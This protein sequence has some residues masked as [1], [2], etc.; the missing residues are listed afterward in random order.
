MGKNTDKETRKFYLSG[1]SCMDCAAKIEGVVSK[2]S[3]VKDARVNFSTSLLK[4]TINAGDRDEANME[5]EIEDEVSKVGFGLDKRGHEAV[6]FKTTGDIAEPAAGRI[7]KALLAIGGVKRVDFFQPNGVKI[8]YDPAQAQPADLKKALEAN[9]AGVSEA[10]CSF[11]KKTVKKSKALLTLTIITGLFIVVGLGFALFHHL[12]IYKTLTVST[13]LFIIASAIGVYY[14]GRSGLASVRNLRLDI[15]FLMCVAVIGA[16]VIGEYLEGATVVFLFMLA[17][18]LETYTMDKARNAIHALVKMSPETALVKDGKNEK[19]V[20]VDNVEVG[21]VIVIKPGEMIPLDGKVLKGCSAV[22]LAAITGESI[23]VEKS[24]GDDVYAGAVNEEGALEVEVTRL[25]KESTLAGIIH[26]IEDAQAQ[27]APFQSFVDKFAKYYTPSVIVC[28]ILV[29]IVPPIVIGAQFTEWFYRALVLLVISCPCA[30]VISTPVS[31][32]SGITAG[33]RKGILFKGGVYLERIGGLRSMAI[34]KTGTLTK[35]EPRVADVAPLNG[36]AVDDVLRIAASVESRSEHSIADAI[37]AKAKEKGLELIE[38][39]KFQSVPGKGAIMELDNVKYCV[40]SVRFMTELGY[41]EPA[42]DAVLKGF[43]D[44]GM[45][46]I[47]VADDK[48][49][50][51]IIAVA[52]EIRKTS[53]QTIKELYN[54]GVKKIVML[55]GDHECAAKAVSREL[56]MLDFR[57]DLPPLDKV[58]AVKALIRDYG[59]CGMIGDGINDAPALAAATV[60]VAM[61]SNATDIAVES[62][63]VT[64]MGDDLR[65]L[66][67]AVDLGKRTIRIIKQ[68][69]MTALLLKGVFLAL[70]APGYTTLWMAV[71]ADMGASLIV[72]CN[73]LRLLRAGGKSLSGK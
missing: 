73:G 69:I 39:D 30:L 52:D 11:S 10:E 41:C 4:V 51:G 12:I 61:G 38:G 59:S 25:S 67:F 5:A 54:K 36:P 50:I 49:V 19:L 22:N 32:I 70:T 45:T 1:L 21:A 40:G 71:G 9:G 68:N 33:A 6:S 55:T 43:Y 48:A 17:Q 13:L 34:D 29:A 47:L 27:K 56:D 35:G 57:S 18:L 53:R 24:E 8:E 64:I 63:D 62:S 65:K 16:A 14:I 60:G 23:P 3:W 46:A 20:P 15:N 58:E 2:L 72:I 37:T 7:R 44:K 28:A 66:P 42:S 26:L 31:L